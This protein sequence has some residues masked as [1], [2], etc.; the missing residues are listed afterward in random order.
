MAIPILTTKLYVPPPRSN[1]VVRRH[2]ITRLNAGL[3]HRL[4]II[5]APAGFGKTTLV[6]EWLASCASRAAWLSLDEGEN[7]LTRFLTYIV[8]AL[9]TLEPTLG[10]ALLKVLQSPQALSIEAL[11]TGLLNDI[12]TLADDFILVLDDYH[13]IEAQPVDHA[14][15]F[16]LEHLP[17]QMHLV[18]ATREIPHL[19]LA[20]FRARGFLTELRAADLQF[21]SAEA[22]EFLTQ[23][24]GLRL[25]DD[26]I[27]ALEARTEGWIAGLQFAAISLQGH[28]DAAGFI[29]AFT[30]S[31]YFVLDYLVEEV[32]Q[33]QA[34][35]VQTFLLRTSIL[36]RL[37]G[38]LCDA[39]VNAS[40]TPGQETLDYLDRANLFLVP[41]D[42]MRHW[43]RYH[44]LFADLL[45]QRLRQSCASSSEDAER[46]I[47][48]LHLRASVWYEQQGLDVEAF[49]HAAAANDVERAARLIEGKEIPLH[50]RGVVAPVLSW[51]AELPPTVLDAKPSL[52]VTYAS[53]L[54]VAN[55]MTDA[56]EKLHAAEAALQGCAPDQD[57]RDL[58]GQIAAIRALMAVGQYSGERIIAQSRRALEHLRPDNLALR[59]ATTWTLGYAYQLQGDRVAARQTYTEVISISRAI[60]NTILIIMA[61]IG[62]GNIQ[63]AD[64]QLA[65]AAETYR[66]ILNLVGEM[67]LPAAACEAHLGLARI[68]YEWNDL[69]AA[70][71]HCRQ[72]IDLAQQ[73]ENTDRGV[74]CEAFLARVL[75]AKGDAT[76][77]AALLAQTNQSARQHD[78]VERVDEIA[79]VQVRTLLRQGKRAAAA[80]L[81]GAHELPLSQA[82]VHLAQGNPSAALAALEPWRKQVEAKGLLDEGLQA[83]ALQSLAL[84]ANGDRDQAAQLL[85]DAL[86]LAEPGGFIRLFVDEGPPMARLLSTA[87]AQGMMPTYVEKL[88][89]AFGAETSYR[90][91]TSSSQRLIEP[92]SKRELEV[93]HLIA[94]GC[95]NQEISER[96]VLA[97][98]TVK[99]HNLKIFGKLQVQ[100]RTEAVAR[101]HE[102]GLL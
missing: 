95:S 17:P 86:A 79:A 6:S 20:R 51:L 84:D 55:H 97:L 87:T 64:N 57:T 1:V 70:E 82:Q 42:N 41:L 8:A 83:M 78:F 74:A 12:A 80:R 89:A 29:A 5:S 27:I 102:L 23:T 96:L 88:L 56:E 91:F 13:V 31:H 65:L 53:A 92:L 100:R 75:L 16:L 47:A 4:T 32:L 99:G 67:P 98:S 21:T 34:E 77:A 93:L 33:Q 49:Q 58:V 22:A 60:G 71:R 72:S 50:F 66:R 63:E 46:G 25:A 7:D 62:L 3:S 40:A 38:S 73:I 24:M 54:V 94:Q 85:V 39:V 26:D 81:A 2:L 45:R 28:R 10:A 44:R 101:A 59:T 19:P 52:W 48:D 37:C 14:L 43:Y 76:G 68:C 90:H 18:I 15:T 61:T 9:Q 69:D 35:R 30:G 36:D 11:L